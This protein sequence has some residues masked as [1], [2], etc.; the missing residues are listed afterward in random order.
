MMDDGLQQDGPA[1]DTLCRLCQQQS[2]QKDTL[3]FDYML[4]YVVDNLM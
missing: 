1:L 4:M 2:W 3:Y